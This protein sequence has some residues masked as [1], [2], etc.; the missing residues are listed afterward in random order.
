MFRSYEANPVTILANYQPFKTK[1]A[2]TFRLLQVVCT[3]P[4]RQQCDAIED[5]TFQFLF[6]IRPRPQINRRRQGRQ[7]TLI[8]SG[9][10]WRQP[11]TLNLRET[12]SIDVVRGGRRGGISA[13]TKSNAVGGATE[14]DKPVDNIGDKAFLVS[15]RGLCQPTHL[16]RQFA[17]VRDSKVFVGQRK[18]PL[19]GDSGQN[20]RFCFNLRLTGKYGNNN[21]LEGNVSTL[22]MEGLLHAWSQATSGAPEPTRHQR[23]LHGKL[24]PRLLDGSHPR[25]QIRV[26][27]SGGAWTQVSRL[28][29]LVNEVVI[30]GRQGQIQCLASAQ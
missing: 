19:Y 27:R 12:F 4:Y 23:L 6:Q 2:P 25:N 18:E 17:G 7:N 16:Q 29:P 5:L 15:V 30:G 9:L 1:A 20:F 28:M 24:A 3:K 10:V 26:R 8:N 14:F 11:F 13:S 21:D 22:A